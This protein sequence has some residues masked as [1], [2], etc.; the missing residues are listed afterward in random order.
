MSKNNDG[1]AAKLL[2][3]FTQDIWNLEPDEGG[4]F[5]ERIRSVSRWIY[6][7]GKGFFGD[8]CIIRASALT[9][10]T[11]LS[12]VPF[13]AVAFS[14]SKGLGLQN[15]EFIRDLL[16]R[17]SAGREQVV[18]NIL[19]Y[20]SNTNVKTLGWL[21]VA[22][23]LVTVYMMISTIEQ[24]FNNIWNV[25]RG[26]TPWRKFTDFF[27]VILICPLLAILAT[28]FTV[29]VQQHQLVQ[30]LL[31]V[32]AIGYIEAV[33]LKLAPLILLWLGFTFVY[34][35]IPNAKVR[36]SSAALGGAVAAILW[37]LAQWVYISWQVGAKNY[38]AI[39]GSFAQL[40]LFL[41]WLYI[42][43]VVVLLGAEV[44]F[45]FQHLKSFTKERFMRKAGL[46]QR[47]KLA[48][49]MLLEMTRRFTR[50]EPQ[51]D[52]AEFSDGLMVPEELVVDIM[53]GLEHEGLVLPAEDEE[54]AYYVPAV[55]PRLVTITRVQRAVACVNGN[56][57]EG[58]GLDGRYRFVD[59]MF[60]AL[61]KA[62][63]ASPANRSLAEYAQEYGERSIVFDLVEPETPE[64]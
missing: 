14:I 17:V 32:S 60:E 35:F 58:P 8:Q 64:K 56:Q 6:L 18:E 3:F 52:V 7:V 28:S 47:Q 11:V 12:I 49:L 37:Q 48:V 16:M 33:L 23:L 9:F 40:P 62:G 57:E 2:R 53:A 41:M 21:G 26:R 63:D 10:T 61:D 36:F 46:R 4:R 39:Y 19:G 13:L 44:S 22:T 24:A 30:T 1:W 29:T 42:S 51:A 15:T 34:S 31:S 5:M 38:N 50:G 43:W 20:I 55:D 45:A 59:T 27:S 25:A 54:R